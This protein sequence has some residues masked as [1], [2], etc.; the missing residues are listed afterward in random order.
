MNCLKDAQDKDMPLSTYF[1]LQQQ[2]YCSDTNI[3]IYLHNKI[4]IN[5]TTYL[6]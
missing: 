3:F 2:L 4:G 1:S 5:Y 6:F